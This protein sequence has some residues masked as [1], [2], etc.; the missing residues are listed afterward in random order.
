MRFVSL[1]FAL[2]VYVLAPNL[3]VLGALEHDCK[4]CPN[5]SA[6]CHHEPTCSDDPCNIAKQGT[7][8]AAQYLHS[9]IDFSLAL[10]PV[11]TLLEKLLYSSELSHSL[12]SHSNAPTDARPHAAYPSSSFPLL[13]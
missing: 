7:R 3:C 11:P 13:V 10:L 8:P 5:Q 1:F 12:L 9:P 6:D 2:F 4:S